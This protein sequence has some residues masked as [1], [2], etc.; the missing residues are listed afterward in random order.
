MY[1]KLFRNLLLVALIACLGCEKVIN[2]DVKDEASKLVIAGNISN[3]PGQ[4]NVRISKTVSYNE[5][6]NF[7]PVSDA[8]V[9]IK[10]DAGNT[11]VLT[12]T[13]PGIYETLRLEGLPGRTYTISVTINGNENYN[14]TS[15]MPHPVSITAITSEDVNEFG[16]T[17]KAI[18]VHFDDPVDIRN[19]YVFRLVHKGELLR[20]V[21]TFDD[22]LY[23]GQS[24]TFKMTKD[25]EGEDEED[26]E[27]AIQPGDEIEVLMMGVDEKVHRYYQQLAEIVES[28]GP[29]TTT[30]NPISNFTG[31]CLGV[32]NAH[33]IDRKSYIVP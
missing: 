12:G 4:Y 1:A 32:F 6:N 21:F 14:A 7:P 22:L 20:Q 28:D 24:I 8:F 18:L 25:I 19:F 33:T 23:D 31:G 10:D 29:L 26:P 30:S 3:M 15:K 17:K 13:A 5:L 9:E 2:Y 11:E 27:L 16:E